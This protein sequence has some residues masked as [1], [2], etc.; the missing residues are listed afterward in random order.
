MLTGPD[1][2]SQWAC[3]TIAF[4]TVERD[5]QKSCST[6]KDIHLESSSVEDLALLLLTYLYQNVNHDIY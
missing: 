3:R 1:E 2:F 6:W 4:V 5:N